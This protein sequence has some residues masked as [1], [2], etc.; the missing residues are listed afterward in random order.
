MVIV[1]S[2]ILLGGL[3]F[4]F[5]LFLSYV[6]EKFKVEEDPTVM[7]VLATLPGANCGACG[8][9]GCEGYAKAIVDNGDRPDKCLP[10]KKSGAEERI[11]E[12]L[13]KRN[14]N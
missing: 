14:S 2:A 5:G 12:I 4:A 10:G 6:G 7:L 1:Y 13:S 3:G 9:P 8:Y 11:K